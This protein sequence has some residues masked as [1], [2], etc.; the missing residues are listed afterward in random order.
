MNFKKSKIFQLLKIFYKG[1]G[2]YK[3]RIVILISLGFLSSLIGALGINALIPLF[4]FVVGQ[5]SSNDFISRAI[6]KFFLFFNLD[7]NIKYLLI[8]I[9]CLFI[10]KAV[11][12]IL[13]NY[14]NVKIVAD[15]EARTRS[16]LFKIILEANWP[17]LLQQ[18]LGHLETVLMTNVRNCSLLLG[19]IS[20]I[21]ILFINLIVYSLIAINIS[22]YVTLITA[23]LSAI[24]L[25]I[26]QPII[27]KTRAISYQEE[28][29][30]RQIAHHIN[31][32]ILGM[33]TVKAM[34]VGENIIRIARDNFNKLKEIKIRT[35]LLSSLPSTL[36]EPFGLIFICII[37]AVSYKT[38]GFNLAVLV[39]VIYLI[40]QIFAYVQ[41]LQ[42]YLL[43][44]SSSIPYLKSIISYEEKAVINKE[45]YSGSKKFKFDDSLEFK[46]VNFSYNSDKNVLSD[47]NFK[48]KKGE[49]VGLIGSSGTGKTTIV[50][51]ILRLFRPISGEIIFDGES[52]NKIDIN[53]W[54]KKIGYVSQDIFL[55]NS[56]IADNI[57]F[58]DESITTEEMESAAK[59]ANIYEFIMSLS[60][61]FDTIIGERGIELSAGQRQRIVIARVLARNPE[62]LILDEA[63]SAL[64]NESEVK[65][66]KIVEDLKGKI[67]AFVIAHRLSTVINCDRLLVLDKG[68]IVEEGTP[69]DLL[70]DK[71]TYFYKVYNIRN[72]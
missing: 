41:Q 61:K 1:F 21:I 30:N 54:R 44:I 10:L 68:R 45:F 49:M 65:I 56:T 26:F 20:T 18:K 66:Q 40:K 33:K 9:V 37:F 48:I 70:K 8:L 28:L 14:I 22:F 51:L 42:K 38:P 15:Y 46:N 35:F 13:T 29:V 25:F 55:K 39:A 11:L 2:R 60:Q 69:A 27:H 71:G 36:M 23:G 62:I 64:D 32:N 4:S 67:T 7:I 47:V 34:S 50:D 59:K 17:Y 3:R 5:G 12:L 24:L 72:K 31:E 57:K 43:G 53:S 16:H 19:Y 52:V 6:A 58:Y 63:T